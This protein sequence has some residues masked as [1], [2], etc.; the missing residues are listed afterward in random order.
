MHSHLKREIESKCRAIPS[1]SA[2]RRAA[3]G[4]EPFGRAAVFSAALVAVDAV[5][6]NEV[7]VRTPRFSFSCGGSGTSSGS[8]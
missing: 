8:R 6:Y 1:R 7:R 4:A 3:I 2:V 5:H